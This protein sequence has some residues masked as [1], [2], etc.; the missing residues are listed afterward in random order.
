MDHRADSLISLLSPGPAAR[1]GGVTSRRMRGLAAMFADPDAQDVL[2]ESSHYARRIIDTP[3]RDATRR[4][5][6]VYVSEA[7]EAEPTEPFAGHLQRLQLSATCEDLWRLA[8]HYGGAA[9]LL[10]VDDGRD[11]SEPI[12]TASVRSVRWVRAVDRHEL[13]PVE[14]FDASAGRRAGEPMRYR[15]HLHGSSGG[16]ILGPDGRSYAPRVHADR[17]IRVIGC[18][19]PRRMAPLYEGWGQSR[20]AVCAEEIL[21]IHKAEGS[22][23]KLLDEFGI[24]IAKI[25][26][27]VEMARSN[28][29]ALLERRMEALAL[30]KSTLR[31]IALDS[32]GEDFSQRNSTVT[33][34]ADIYSQV[35]IPALA[36]CAEMPITLIFGTTPKGLN[37][38]DDKAGRE[39]YHVSIH[40]R[41]VGR[42]QPV[43]ERVVELVRAS[44]DGPGVAEDAELRIE[45]ASLD[46]LTDLEAAELRQ[47]QQQTD[48]GYWEM[49]VLSE[50]EVR[51]SRFGGAGYSTDTRLLEGEEPPAPDTAAS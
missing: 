9:L 19:I 50:R 41:Q 36:S 40:S 30:S 2:Y 45:W 17:V 14:W 32:D 16:M 18:P 4:F 31:L 34:V 47:K 29:R 1:P 27:L 6:R 7:D 11:P 12:D 35:N 23:E 44:R 43:V 46:D 21:R 24:A 15:L 42:L 39:N 25:K 22:I 10:D 38:G 48:R 20:L 3:A 5:C 33:G 8:E 28:N 51:H 26:G 37:A 13:Q 49:G